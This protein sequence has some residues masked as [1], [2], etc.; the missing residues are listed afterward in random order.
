MKAT[1]I[2]YWVTTSIISLMMA[3]AGFAYLTQEKVI[4]GFQHLGYPGYFRI[5][6]A[7]A[8]FVAAIVLI[9]PAIPERLKEWA[10]AGLGITFISAAIAHIVSGDPAVEWISP[11]IIL[12][13]VA[14]SYITWHKL[15]NKVSA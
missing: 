1:K 5:E 11:I 15:H 7:I 8:K 3:F 9:I 6:L 13:I 12:A 14:G 10:Y 2:P 4:Q